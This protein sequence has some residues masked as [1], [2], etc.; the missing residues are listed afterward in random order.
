[1]YRKSLENVKKHLLIEAENQLQD[2]KLINSFK[3][4]NKLYSEQQKFDTAKKII[5]P[6]FES[7]Q[8]NPS[9]MKQIFG[10][11]RKFADLKSALGEKNAY[12]L[13]DIQKYYVQPIERMK[14]DFKVKSL[15]D[16][17]E[18]IEGAAVKELA[19]IHVA[20]VTKITPRAKARL[21]MSENTQN[22]WVRLM[23]SIKDG[24]VRGVK[25]YSEDLE[26]DLE[27]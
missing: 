14:D 9:K 15:Y 18:L 10:S 5:D 11:E 24:S 3:Q 8:F 12:R 16:L 2:P 27:E 19:G 4:Q 7:G 6:L 26:K 17:G 13:K 25:K 1:M 23:R 20:L 22:L 21:L